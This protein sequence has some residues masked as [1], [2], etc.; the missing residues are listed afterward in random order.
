MVVVL[1]N[2]SDQIIGLPD[3]APIG[4][5]AE[6]DIH[7]I[8]QTPPAGLEPATERL[9]RLRRTRSTNPLS[10]QPRT[11]TPRFEPPLTTHRLRPGLVLLRINKHPGTRVLGG[12]LHGVVRWIIVLSHTTIQVIGLPDVSLLSIHAEK[13]IHPINQTPP[14]G[15]EP[16][17]ERLIRLRRTRSTNPLS[18]QPRT[19]TPRFE[20]PLTTHRLRPGLVLLRIN[21]HPGTRVL[22]GELHGVVRW[23]IVLSHTT[24][25]VIGLPDV[26]LLSIYAEK[27]IHPINQ[28]PP[29][30][31]EP[32]T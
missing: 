16:A 23:I 25:Q 5:F 28:T 19:T 8:N 30:G 20:P 11:T 27:N 12:E 7:P 24:I 6:Q 2:S 21:K 3:V 15:L 1:A 26:S 18:I 14:A 31:L 9:I 4:G 17:T 32:A 10:I 13:D 29:A 22:G